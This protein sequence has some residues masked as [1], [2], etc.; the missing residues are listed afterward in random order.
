MIE[1]ETAGRPSYNLRGFKERFKT[2]NM[3]LERASEMY[4]K[5]KNILAIC[6]TEHAP[7]EYEGELAL[8]QPTGPA[9]WHQVS[10]MPNLKNG[11]HRLTFHQ[12]LELYQI[13]TN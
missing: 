6:E 4:Q 9:W 13:K 7:G 3:P 5:L 11:W 8:F 10:W 2:Q 1:F 12:F